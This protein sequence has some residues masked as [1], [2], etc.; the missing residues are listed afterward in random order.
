MGKLFNVPHDLVSQTQ[1]F[2]KNILEEQC[3]YLFRDT[4]GIVIGRV[5][6]YSGSISSNKT[7]ILSGSIQEKLGEVSGDTFTYEFFLTSKCT[8]DYKFRVMFMQH[9]ITGYPLTVT[10]EEGIS[11]EIQYSSTGY[12]YLAENQEEFEELL[13]QILNSSRFM[14][15]VTR[16]IQLNNS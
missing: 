1:T 11:N 14:E 8:P 13:K 15:I 5:A 3:Q 2:P 12:E 4:N 6:E 9:D 7:F 16:L 10:L